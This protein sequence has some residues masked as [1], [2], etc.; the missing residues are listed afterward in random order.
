MF[1]IIDLIATALLTGLVVAFVCIFTLG[2]SKINR[3]DDIY[4]E[5]YD[6]GY[7]DGKKVGVYGE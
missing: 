6:K 5:G 2:A 1:G 4:K 3:E 7:A